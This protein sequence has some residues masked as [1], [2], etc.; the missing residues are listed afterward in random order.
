VETSMINWSEGDNIPYF[1]WPTIPNR[2]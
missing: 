2:T 1:K